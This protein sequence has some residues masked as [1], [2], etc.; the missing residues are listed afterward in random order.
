MFTSTNRSE[1]GK[2]FVKE[3]TRERFEI[4][5]MLT[6]LVNSPDG[7]GRLSQDKGWGE[8]E[9]TKAARHEPESEADTAW[10]GRLQTLPYVC[11]EVLEFETCVR[12][13]LQKERH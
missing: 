11:Q 5:P 8:G 7:P 4:V 12:A 3:P 6:G 9:G 1:Q 13:V 2:V 10:S